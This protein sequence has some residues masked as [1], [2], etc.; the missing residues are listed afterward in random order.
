LAGGFIAAIVV[1]I[2]VFFLSVPLDLSLHF[3]ADEKF[4]FLFRFKWLFGLVK[5]GAGKRKKK[6]Q[7][8]VRKKGRWDWSFLWGLLR[9]RGL[10]GKL[11]RFLR[12][13]LRHLKIRDLEVD[14][15]VGLGDPADTAL[16]VG[17][18]WLPTFLTSTQTGHLIRVVPSFN[19]DLVFQGHAYIS[20]RLIPIQLVP[21]FVRFGFSQP[22]IMI[23]RALIFRRWKRKK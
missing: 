20:I 23:L 18:I 15:E 19:D 2:I 22:G 8:K 1:G 6:P 21:A 9:T 14:L 10:P 5:T 3:E 7:R 4:R 11:L 17:W 13:I 12:D 16:F